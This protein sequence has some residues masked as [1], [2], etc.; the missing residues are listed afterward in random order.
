MRCDTVKIIWAVEALC[1]VSPPM[2][3]AMRQRLRIGDGA[4]RR[5]PRPDRAEGVGC[6]AGHPLRDPQLDGPGAHVVADGVARN[7]RERGVRREVPRNRAHDDGQLALVVDRLV[8]SEED[9]RATGVL[10]RVGKLGEDLRE[11][12][13]SDVRLRGVEPVVHADA[14]DLLGVGNGGQEAH[15]IER[16][17]APRGSGSE[18]R[19]PDAASAATPMRDASSRQ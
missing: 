1:S 10:D 3:V 14:D 2:V 12:R 15:L 5:H 7:R 11:R 6:L 9:D 8:D 13:R 19:Q 18:S 16:L 17:R 4:R